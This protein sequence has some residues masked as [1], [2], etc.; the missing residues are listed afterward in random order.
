MQI[1]ASEVLSGMGAVLMFFVGVAVFSLRAA[2]ARLEKDDERII[3]RL[4]DEDGKIIKRFVSE[5]EKLD[6]KIT[7]NTKEIY[8]R[9]N[10][11]DR[12]ISGLCAE[13]NR[14]FSSHNRGEQ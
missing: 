8:K 1:G 2:L 4:E 13:H 10:E 9:I 5:T 14:F 6:I 11:L 7:D 12:K 3:K